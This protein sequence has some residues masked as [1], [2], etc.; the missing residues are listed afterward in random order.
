MVSAHEARTEVAQAVEG[1]PDPAAIKRL[2]VAIESISD[3]PLYRDNVV[4][5]LVDGPATYEVMF[6]EIAGA[7]HHI[8]LETYIFNDDQVGRKFAD[9][10]I[11]RSRAGVE[12]RV[13]YDSMGSR[14]SDSDFFA[15][16]EDAGIDC[17]AFHP[18]NPVD[19]GNP[20]DAN[21]RD[22]RKL[23]VVDGQVAFTGGINIDRNY[24]SSSGLFKRKNK[25]LPRPG[26]WRDTH[27]AVRGPAVEGFQQ[28]FLDHWI[29]QGGEASR[30]SRDYFPE[31]GVR[32]QHLVR[33]LASAGGDDGVSQIRTAYQYAMEAATQR[34]WLTHSYFGPDPELLRTMGK[35][36]QRGVDVRIML[37]GVSDSRL[38]L[39]LSR[40][41]Y[42]QLLKAGVKVYESD[43]IML[44]A[45]TAVVD[46][47]W[48][49]VGSSNLDYRSFIHNDEV[50]AVIVG[51]DIGKRL[52]DL[53]RSDLQRSREISL[54]EWED[55]SWLERITEWIASL[56][57]YWL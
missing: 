48:S 9:A 17:I 46:R 16:L 20:L 39:A 29:R 4:E 49:T 1:A 51:A 42:T 38:M 19:G 11:E 15:R 50:N 2:E 12:V 27:I 37:S 28:L 57:R 45:K 56:F 41:Y 54:Q 52:E 55:R 18:V 40:S 23:L 36:A 14:E 26:G 21:V 10:L 25:P 7:R 24:S 32:G 6:R 33:V 44:H 30:E 34:I 43:D 13:I 5:L 47:V 53:F 8:H 35:A 3:Q 31:P 22:H